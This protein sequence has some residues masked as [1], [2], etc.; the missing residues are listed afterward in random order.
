MLSLRFKMVAVFSFWTVAQRQYPEQCV[1]VWGGTVRP[2]VHRQLLQKGAGTPPPL[3]SGRRGLL[4]GPAMGFLQQG[5]VPAPSLPKDLLWAGHFLGPQLVRAGSWLSSGHSRPRLLSVGM[6]E[7][8]P[9]GTRPLAGAEPGDP[10][11]LLSLTRAKSVL[12][13]LRMLSVAHGRQGLG[14]GASLGFPLLSL[15]KPKCGP[16]HS[17]AGTMG[18]LEAYGSAMQP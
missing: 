4:P 2:P 11:R 6:G 1:C 9:L 13:H 8:Q 18:L 17:P 3:R 7:Q 10:R 5:A 15:C 14:R 12:A 16:N